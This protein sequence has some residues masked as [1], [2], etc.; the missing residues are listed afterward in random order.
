MGDKQRAGAIRL[1]G[2]ATSVAGVLI[3]LA[4]GFAAEIDGD[5]GCRAEQS[6]ADARLMVEAMVCEP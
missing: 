5:R 1:A 3:S 6:I 2:R 4:Q